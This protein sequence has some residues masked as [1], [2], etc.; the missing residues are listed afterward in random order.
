[1]SAW[2]WIAIGGA[3]YIVAL[4][5]YGTKV[6]TLVPGEGLLLGPIHA[7]LNFLDHGLGRPHDETVRHNGTKGL[8]ANGNQ[9][10]PGS[11]PSEAWSVPLGY[12]QRG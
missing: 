10:N 6:E 5:I 9:S 1:V 11:F 12:G 3:A 8:L 2:K 4:A 7:G